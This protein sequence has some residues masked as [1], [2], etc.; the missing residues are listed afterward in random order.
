MTEALPLADRSPDPRAK[1]LSLAEAQ[2]LAAE[3]ANWRIEGN[4][5]R[6]DFKVRDFRAATH[7]AAQIAQVADAMDHH[8][9]LELG[10]GRVRCEIWT[11][12]ASGLTVNDFILAARI[13]RI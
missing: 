3:L 1:L 12:S 7:F 10:Y 4:R 9:D 13:D 8:P 6:R 11:H 5:L 2:A